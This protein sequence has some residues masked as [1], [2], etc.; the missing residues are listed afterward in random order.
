MKKLVYDENTKE[1]NLIE[2]EEVNVTKK[3]NEAIV[4]EEVK[5]IRKATT[6]EKVKGKLK[7][8]VDK[9]RKNFQEN[10]IFFE[11]FSLFFLGIMG[12]VISGVGLKVNKRTA[13]IYQKQ[14]EILVNDREPGFYS[15]LYWTDAENMEYVYKIENH[16]GI[17]SDCI[18]CPILKV[19]FFINNEFIYVSFNDGFAAEKLEDDK[20]CVI[21]FKRSKEF[22]SELEKELGEK[23]FSEADYVM[24][25]YINYRNESIYSYFSLESEGMY[26]V[27]RDK[28]INP[29]GIYILYDGNINI[30]EIADK[31]NEMSEYEH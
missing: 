24:L 25:N 4:A 5:E 3:I 21:D 20:Q 15:K 31:I 7:L 18:V 17:A 12:I 30:K 11:V 19:T 1:V 28:A 2:Q 27:D 23:C 6:K 22:I 10:K 9:L 13:D 16:G 29:N 26:A 8:K 14:L